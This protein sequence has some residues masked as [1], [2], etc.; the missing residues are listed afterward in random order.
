M[1]ARS[2]PPCFD[3]EGSIQKHD[4]EGV[5]VMCPRLATGLMAPHIVHVKG[6]LCQV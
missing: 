3:C 1:L 5:H 6:V 2:N 4:V